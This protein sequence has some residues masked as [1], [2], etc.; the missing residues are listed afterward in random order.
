VVEKATTEHKQKEELPPEVKR[1]NWGAFIL[2]WIWGLGNR[3]YLALI[4]L[5]PGINIIMAFVLGALGS[6]LAWNNRQW[7]S[8]EQF[9]QVQKLWSLFGLGV[10]AGAIIGGLATFGLVAFIVM[11][12]FF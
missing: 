11:N 5:I 12:V 3:T 6:R 8:L 10:L 2:N 1:W 7:D 4:C 9:V